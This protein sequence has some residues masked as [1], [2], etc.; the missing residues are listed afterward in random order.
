MKKRSIYLACLSLA[1]MA[2]VSGCGKDSVPSKNVEHSD[3]VTEADNETKPTET[4]FHD[5][6]GHSKEND[7][8]PEKHGAVLERTSRYGNYYDFLLNE[9]GTDNAVFSSESL[10]AAFCVYSHLLTE[11]GR[12]NVEQYLGNRDYLGY[13]NTDVFKSI[14]RIWVNTNY[15]VH[16]NATDVEDLGYSLDMSDS[17]NATAEKNDYVIDQTNGF[18]DGTPTILNNE[19]VFDVM[20]VTYFK[21]KWL[22]GD[23]TLTDELY[24]FHNANG[25]TTEVNMLKGFDGILCAT[26]NAHAFTTSYQDG[27]TFT[28]ILPDEGVSLA[29]VDVEA[30]ILDKAKTVN[31]DC[32]FMM[33]EF[34]T[35]SEYEFSFDTFGIDAGVINPDVYNGD[36]SSVISQVAKIKV[37]SKGTEAAAVTEIL[38]KS[39][40]IAEERE[41]Y[42]MTCD[43]PFVYYIYDTVNDD[44]AFIGVVN[45]K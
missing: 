37:D 29:D 30:F 14:N 5:E 43:R 7:K 15:D 22:G 24:K 33:P 16:M 38:V 36:V 23:K 40:A 18:L 17:K 10:D 27:F 39:N 11:E 25:T 13:E 8:K 3:S 41:I 45:C 31:A 12:H 34:E 9:A 21:D 2:M 4:E 1:V 26:D 6:S 42:E 35:K 32:R 19:V 28:A 20:N 44:V